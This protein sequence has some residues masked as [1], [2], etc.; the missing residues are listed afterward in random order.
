LDREEE[1]VLATAGELN[2]TSLAYAITVHKAQGSEC[3][4]VFFLTHHRH[5]AM[6]YRELVYTAI[7]RAAEELHFVLTPFCLETAAKKPRIKGD[8]LAAKLEYFKKVLSER[9]ESDE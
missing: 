7:T 3:R 6:M 2:T 8:T 5:S 9:M 1:V 4:K